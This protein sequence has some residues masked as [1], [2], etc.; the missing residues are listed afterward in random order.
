[1]NILFLG[2][3]PTFW[4]LINYSANMCRTSYEP[5]VNVVHEGI[6]SN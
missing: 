1:M 2:A 5:T 3:E 6:K 4:T